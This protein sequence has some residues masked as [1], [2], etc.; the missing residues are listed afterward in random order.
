MINGPPINQTINGTGF[1]PAVGQVRV[2]PTYDEKYYYKGYDYATG[3]GEILL[4]SDGTIQEN[5]A[6]T[7][8]LLILG[9]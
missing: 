5:G 3:I 1:H 7:N 6:A 9:C 8:G 2:Q 4:N